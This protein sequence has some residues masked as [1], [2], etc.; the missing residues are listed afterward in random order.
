MN[1]EGPLLRRAR[2]ST[3]PGLA[4]AGEALGS[5]A[6]S[7]TEAWRFLP[8][9]AAGAPGAPGRR[10]IAVGGVQGYRWVTSNVNVEQE[11]AEYPGPGSGEAIV[12]VAEG[13]TGTDIAG[14]LVEQGVIKTPGPFVNI[15]SNTPDASRIEPGIY[16]LKLEMTSAGCTRCALGPAEP[17]R[18]SRDHPRGQAG[19]PDLAAAGRG[20]RHPCR[21]LRGGR[22]GLHQYG[23]PK[24]SAKSLEGYLAP[25]R[26]DIYEDATAEDVITMMWERMEKQLIGRGIAEAKW[27]E[28]L[29]V[30][31]LAEMEV[32]Q[33]GR[34]RQGR[35]HHLQP[36]R[37]S[38]RGRG[39]PDEAPVRLDHP[40]RDRQVRER[41]HHLR[42]ARDEQPLQHL[43][44]CRPAARADRRPRCRDALDAAMD[45]PEGD[46]LYFVSVNTD[47][48]ETKFAATWAEHEENVEEWQD[49]AASKG[50]MSSAP[51][52]GARLT[53]PALALPVLHRTAYELLGLGRTPSTNG[54]RCPPAS[55][56]TS[57]HGGRR[58]RAAWIERHH[59]R[60]ARGVRAGGG[61][62]RD[63][64]PPRHLEHPDPCGRRLACREPRRPRHRRGAARPWR[65]GTGDGRRAR[66]RSDRAERPRRAHR[67]RCAYGA[68]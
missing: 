45:P 10:R 17:G 42:R 1:D 12:E 64:P 46:W 15:F 62:R 54:M 4:P 27:H 57:S 5:G 11:A 21:G 23:I 30:A 3:G 9:C 39:I 55:S 44:L 6:T 66:L 20:D 38:R 68:C 65:G 16:Q 60:E 47:T 51:L 34:L 2:R 52:R 32:R 61:D 26:Y 37:G 24:N 31:S 50:E 8:W 25:G 22:G 67:A 56:R 18:S 59:A 13:D 33:R 63:L 7:R 49:W 36:P 58:A 43:P 48:G 40:L 19:R 53:G 29:T 14:T 41:R 28:S 35:P